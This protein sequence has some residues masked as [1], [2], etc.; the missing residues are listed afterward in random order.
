M[1]DDTKTVN[2]HFYLDESGHEVLPGEFLHEILDGWYGFMLY[3]GGGF[4]PLAIAVLT[5]S[6][7]GYHGADLSEA[8]ST[9]EEWARDTGRL[10]EIHEDDPDDEYF[11]QYKAMAEGI[12]QAPELKVIYNGRH[13]WAAEP[14]AWGDFGHAD[15]HSDRDIFMHDVDKNLPPGGELVTLTEARQYLIDA[16]ETS[17]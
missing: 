14:Q 2:A 7:R 16:E 8:A 5:S 17:D 4:C 3:V 12:P 13:Y 10:S 9:F 6:A 15:F 1:F 11:G